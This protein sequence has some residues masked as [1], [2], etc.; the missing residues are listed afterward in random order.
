VLASLL[1]LWLLCLTQPSYDEAAGAN[2]NISCVRHG[3]PCS[4]R[5]GDGQFYRTAES[6]AVCIFV[7]RAK[8]SFSKQT[9][10]LKAK[11]NGG[12]ARDASPGAETFEV[13][14]SPASVFHS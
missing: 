12:V 1:L 2:F 7:I 13:Q 3:V 11:Q 8:G 9:V 5:V 6:S 4:A 14:L 10:A